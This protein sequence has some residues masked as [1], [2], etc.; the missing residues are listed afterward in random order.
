MLAVTKYFTMPVSGK[1]QSLWWESYELFVLSQ[2]PNLYSEHV[3]CLACSKSRSPTLA[4]VKIGS[5]HSTSNLQSHKRSHHSEEYDAITKR[6]NLKNPQSTTHGE[7]VPT[8]TR[9]I[10]GFVTKLNAKCAK[11]VYRTA[12]A[13]LA[14]EEGIPFC[15]FEQPLF[16]RLFTPLNHESGRIVKLQCHQVKDAVIEMGDYVCVCV[17]VSGLRLQLGYCNA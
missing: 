4:I 2:H 17:C 10:P 5:S 7:V 9:N 8:S 11:L 3:M 16:L 13:M 1:K 6:V 15:I 12:A 14:I